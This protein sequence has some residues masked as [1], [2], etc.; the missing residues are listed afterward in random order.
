MKAASTPISLRQ[1]TSAAIH[2]LGGRRSQ[3]G[4]L[5]LERFALMKQP[6]LQPRAVD[7]ADAFAVESSRGNPGAHVFVDVPACNG[8]NP[9]A[10]G[11]DLRANGRIERA[12]AEH[13]GPTGM[14][15]QDDVV[16][17]E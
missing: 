2:V 6:E 1:R 11:P 5:S 12:A 17:R 16:H 10:I 7:Y 13:A 4:H 15:D 3:L 8:M 14:I 9:D